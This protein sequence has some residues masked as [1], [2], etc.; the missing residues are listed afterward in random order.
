MGIGEIQ[1]AP[2]AYG[3]EGADAKQDIGNQV[4]IGARPMFDSCHHMCSI[5]IHE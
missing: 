3:N 1:C 4:E 5:V 2:A